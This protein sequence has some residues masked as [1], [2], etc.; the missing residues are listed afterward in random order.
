MIFGNICSQQET[1]QALEADVSIIALVGPAHIGKCE[2][3]KQELDNSISE[4]DLLEVDHTVTSSR[5]VS[6][7]LLS[8]PLFSSYRAVLVSDADRLTE[9]AQD[10][11]LKLFEEP[12]K[13]VKICLIL[14]DD[15]FLLPTLQSRIQKI[16]RWFPLSDE[17]M[18]KYIQTNSFPD[19]EMI[20]RLSGGRPGFYELLV[21][22]PLFKDLYTLIM[23]IIQDG[24]DPTIPTPIMLKNTSSGVSIEKD[25][26]ARICL[27]VTLDSV[28]QG[29]LYF[30]ALPFLKFSSIITKYPATN[31]EIYWQRACL[32]AL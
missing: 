4:A 14:N 13:N 2:F 26:I 8:S 5:E 11:Y 10:A 25:L 16:V 22:Q 21:A 31:V 17:D 28:H 27:Q 24:F 9:P 12:P 23:Q 20:K 29:I 1:R 3:L 15:G 18:N 7:F 30:K 32:N 6:E 19:D